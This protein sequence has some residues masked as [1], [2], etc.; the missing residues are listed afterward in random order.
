MSSEERAETS[1]QKLDF[2][3]PQAPVEMTHEQGFILNN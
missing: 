2:S 3:T 1:I